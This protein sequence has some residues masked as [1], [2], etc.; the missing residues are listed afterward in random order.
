MLNKM[1]P[2]RLA[3]DEEESAP[4]STSLGILGGIR[5]LDPWLHAAMAVLTLASSVRY[6]SAHGWDSRTVVVMVGTLILLVLYA[7]LFRIPSLSRPRRALTWT[8]VLIATW[9]VLVL[10]APSFAWVSIPLA[11]IVLR[12]LPFRLAAVV[13]VAMMA[14]VVVAWTNMVGT[15]DPTIILG[16]VTV[17]ILAIVTYR[18]LERESSARQ[19]LVEQLREAQ[20]D[21]A[22][23][24]HEAGVMAER[25][26]LSREIHDSL[27]QTLTSINLLLQAAQKRWQAQPDS[28]REDVEHAADA[29]RDGLT[30]VRRVIQDLAPGELGADDPQE[31]LAAA[32]ERI[33]RR[34]LAGTDVE[35][36]MRVHGQVRQVPTDVASALL[37]STR[38][39]LANVIE[40]AGAARVV[41]S[42]T[43]QPDGVS[44]DVRDDGRGFE[45]ARLH[46]ATERGHGLA[47]IR[48]RT[49]QFGGRVSV[50][51]EPG[52]GTAVAVWIPSEA[53]G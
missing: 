14:T 7:A 11:F 45:A 2:T 25:T 22:H 5:R 30:E 1:L 8:L 39:L 48:S 19:Q 28:A 6:V 35:L 52:Q 29:A 36:D 17:A 34:A 42:L 27:A 18:A 49:R 32:L 47:G 13:L 50:E 41:V 40:H 9:A 12:E 23:A 38:G 33:C 53:T 46:P 24:Q 10:F 31:A 26:R 4:A 15:L 3:L 20:L 21:L 44:I 37:R 43:Y 16:P 51:S